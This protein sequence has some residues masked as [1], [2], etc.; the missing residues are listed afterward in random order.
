[1][2][3]VSTLLLA[4]SIVGI[5]GGLSLLARGFAG[6]RRAG[7]VGDTATSRIDTLA[8]GE[9]RVTGRVEPAELALTS[10]LQSQTCVYYR[11][12]VREQDSRT[13]RTVLDD[14]RAVGFRV[15]D[16]TGDIRVFPRGA[17]WDVPTRFKDSDG[18]TGDKPAGLALRGGSAIQP[19]T[20]DREE[21]VAQ[22]LMA[23]P[24]FGGSGLDPAAG[25][26][27]LGLADRLGAGAPAG[28]RDYE[29]SRIEFGD[30]I[31]VVGTALPF[32]QL[33]DPSGADV[34]EGEALGGPLAAAA[35]PEIAADLEAARAAG[36]LETDADEAWGNAAIPG[37]GIGKPVR[38]PELDPAATPPAVADARTAERF[39]RTFEIAPTELVLAIGPDR[40]M[41]VS[42]GAPAAVVTRGQD[43]F[44]VGLFGA[45]L[46]IV[47]AIVLALQVGGGLLP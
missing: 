45:V 21:L 35:D 3:D 22:L 2:S 32:D 16:E 44:L 20:P 26:G 10:P 11:A 31:T 36:T 34:S 4:G 8:V 1:M 29:E 14:E 9:V 17:T 46:A 18:F 25:G 39:E 7:R 33:P 30:T 47:S 15:R 28:R 23:R 19:A 43:R 6:Y 5:G 38:P 41:L 13:R 42:F 24:S 40:P 37:F 27:M 12:R